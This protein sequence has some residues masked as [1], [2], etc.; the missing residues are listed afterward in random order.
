MRRYSE[1]ARRELASVLIITILAVVIGISVAAPL[2]PTRATTNWDV[3]MHDFYF[4]PKF[5]YVDPG[6][7]VTWH[8]NGAAY[9]TATSNTSA[10][11]T[12]D[13]SPGTSSAPITM[14]LTPGNYTYHC[15]Y[16]GGPPFYMWGAIIVSTAVPEFSSSFVVVAGMLVIALGLMLVRRK[17]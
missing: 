8:N 4:S 7:T 6:D 11:D 10:W 13:V 1:R 16:H 12:G 14:P 9:H 5:T 2:M 17:T 3:Q 15:F